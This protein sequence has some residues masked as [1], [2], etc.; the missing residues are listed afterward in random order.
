MAA[1]AACAVACT[2][3][4]GTCSGGMCCCGMCCCGGAIC[5][6]ITTAAFGFDSLKSS[7]T[8]TWVK[9]LDMI[10]LDIGLLINLETIKLLN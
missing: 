1:V 4:C 10:K 7:G 8:G 9:G 5:S 2:A 3:G 6:P